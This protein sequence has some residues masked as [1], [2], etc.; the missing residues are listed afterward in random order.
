MDY[1]RKYLKRA[2]VAG[3][4]LRF[5]PF[6]RLAGLNG[7]LARGTDHKNSDIDFLIIV[8]RGR[9]YSA[10]FFATILIH[11]TGWRRHG[12]KIAGRICLN[13][14]LPDDEPSVYPHLAES[15]EKV[16]KSNRN[17]V[18]LVDEGGHEESF[19]AKNKWMDRFDA[20]GL[21]YAA[22]IKETLAKNGPRRPRKSLEWIL[23]GRLG[24]ILEKKLMEFQKKRILRGLKEGDETVA[25]DNE[26]RLHPKK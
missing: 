10:R 13:C 2:K 3:N 12:K 19:F 11:L 9:L 6:L 21:W 7:S 24:N 18:V 16:A 5:V 1:R 23:S 8:K 20:D 22:E 25:E 4:I 14:F 26:I 17:L 15:A